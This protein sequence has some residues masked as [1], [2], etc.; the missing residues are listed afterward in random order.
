MNRYE[1]GLI[2]KSVSGFLYLVC[3]MGSSL[4]LSYGSFNFLLAWLYLSVFNVSV[5]AITVYLFV[6]DKQLLKSRLAG[7]TEYCKKVKYRL[8]PFIF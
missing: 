1:S 5:I 3:L 8:I 2:L 4:F 7:Y 6:F